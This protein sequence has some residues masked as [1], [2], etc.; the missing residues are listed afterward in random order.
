MTKTSNTLFIAG[1]SKCMSVEKIINKFN[2]YLEKKT[3]YNEL[4]IAIYPEKGYGF[5]TLD[6]PKSVSKAIKDSKSK[7]GIVIDNY[8]LR[9]EVSKKSV[10][11]SQ[12]QKFRHK[13]GINKQKFLFKSYSQKVSDYDTDD[14]NET[15]LLKPPNKCY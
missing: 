5:I 4:M 9:L 14:E 15:I 7:R 1:I 2:S 11:M 12:D 13:L 6:S 8:R 3:R 10:K